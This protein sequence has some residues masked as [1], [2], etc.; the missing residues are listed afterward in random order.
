MYITIN[1]DI[2]FSLQYRTKRSF[3]TDVILGKTIYRKIFKHIM[4][5]YSLY[6]IKWIDKETIRKH[7][8]RFTK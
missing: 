5:H 1:T 8:K 3:I 7:D 4:W 6:G 2:C